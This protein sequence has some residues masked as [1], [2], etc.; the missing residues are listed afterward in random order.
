MGT[1]LGDIEAS[2]ISEDNYMLYSLLFEANLTGVNCSHILL[3]N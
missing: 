1:Q 3:S 2:K